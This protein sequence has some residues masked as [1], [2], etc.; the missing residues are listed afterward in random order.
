MVRKF[1]ALALILCI[2]FCSFAFFAQ[3]ETEWN[4]R[5][6]VEQTSLNED[7]SLVSLRIS[8]DDITSESGVVCAI[9][10]LQFDSNCLEY[11]A[12]ENGTPENWLFGDENSLVAQD[13]SGLISEE[14]KTPYFYYTIF[15][16]AATNG[17]TEDGVLYTDLTFRIIDSSKAKTEIVVSEIS[18]TDEEGL[19]Q[20]YSLELPNVS[21]T[22]NLKSEKPGEESGESFESQDTISGTSSDVTSSEQSQTT[23]SF[24][25]STPEETELVST[26]VMLY[27]I[28]DPSGVSIL[29]FDFIFDPNLLEFVRYEFIRP[30]VWVDDVKYTEDLT[31]TSDAT[32]GKIH[33][34]VLNSDENCGVK[35]SG[36]LG[37]RVY[38]NA[39]IGLTLDSSFFTFENESVVNALLLDV[40]PADYKL[41]VGEQEFQNQLYFTDLLF[42][43]EDSSVDLHE[44]Q[45]LLT[46]DPR[47]C[48]Y[49]KYEVMYADGASDKQIV[50][51][52][53]QIG[54]AAEGTLFFR[55]ESTDSATSI[56]QAGILGIR[57]YF[58]MTNDIQF[59]SSLLNIDE[60]V[61]K[62]AKGDTLDKDVFEIS[63]EGASDEK[64]FWDVTK[65]I[66][67]VVGVVI[68]V[69]A[70][71]LVVLI[72]GRKKKKQ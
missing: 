71:V 45:F 30:S 29:E 19:Y 65:V 50:Q 8:I 70:G 56:T 60:I 54:S 23:E 17:V 48:T 59:D 36:V 44:L 64:S 7:D 53:S 41:L 32:D 46:F 69:A 5:L 20:N 18:L 11:I 27:D 42:K 38:F 33:F 49:V 72:Y 25:A 55:F 21:H 2:C 15:N 13:W 34:C 6:S 62:N 26:T 4:A 24:V 39:P 68:V 58:H 1:F 40:P 22:L 61:A 16:E 31:V 43:V 66:V 51:D 14:G 67:M 12:H 57:V 35:E 3:A 52:R 28:K 63:I 47:L 9:Y 10:S 37:F